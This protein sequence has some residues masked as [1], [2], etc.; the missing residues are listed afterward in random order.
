MEVGKRFWSGQVLFAE[1]I[2]ITLEI[3]LE[4]K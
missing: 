2:M 3:T 1:W 4:E